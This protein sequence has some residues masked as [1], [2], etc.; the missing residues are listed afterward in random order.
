MTRMS[1][2][3][4]VTRELNKNRITLGYIIKNLTRGVFPIAFGFIVLVIIAGILSPAFFK[5]TNI[6]NVLRQVSINCIISIGMTFVI[7]TGGIDLSVGSVVALCSV[8]VAFAQANG[9]STFTSVMV[10]LG[11]GMF[12]GLFNGF[13][14]VNRKLQPFIVTL[15]S[16]TIVRGLAYIISGGRPIMGITDSFRDIAI[17][18]AGPLPMPALYMLILVG[19][20]YVV[21]SKTFWGRAYYA[22]GGNEE[23]A[24]LSGTRVDM[25][26]ALA[27][28]LTGV[29]SGFSAILVV[30]R[31][32]VG[33]PIIGTGWELDAIA[34]VVIGGTS[35]A[36]GVGS[37]IGTFIGALILG[38]LSNIFNLLNISA[39]VQMV[40]KGIIIL[41]AVLAS[42][43]KKH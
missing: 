18:Y 31:V 39:Y 6:F 33:E 27:Y 25:Y 16:M 11:A 7:L 17:T 32:T 34:A 35:L 21:L 42:T 4:T 10:G 12:C 22:I 15:A 19:F 40:F 24:R 36:G 23:A 2:E 1:D 14:I 28:V 8:L 43:G 38:V 20:A 3:I 30:A 5:P 9:L 41:I 29:L 37:V 26:K 13:I